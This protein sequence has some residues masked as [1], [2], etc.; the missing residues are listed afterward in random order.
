MMSEEAG[1]K[2]PSQC[3]VSVQYII[4][5]ST[6]R[7]CN[8]NISARLFVYIQ[9]ILILTREYLHSLVM[10]IRKR[11]RERLADYDSDSDEDD[12]D[13][14]EVITNCVHTF[15]AN[16]SIVDQETCSESPGLVWRS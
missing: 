14:R 7:H 6:W 11:K 4:I 3:T 5:S 13:Q 15:V 16:Q 10:D 12:D 9:H 8:N 2:Y 1:R